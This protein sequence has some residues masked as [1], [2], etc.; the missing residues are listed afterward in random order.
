MRVSH[1]YEVRPFS[2]L[3]LLLRFAT[4]H[5]HITGLQQQHSSSGAIHSGICPDII[6]I[7]WD[8][9]CWD[10]TGIIERSDSF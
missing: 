10:S 7:P 6:P 1:Y 9:C 3:L 4:T 5:T 2:L 8:S